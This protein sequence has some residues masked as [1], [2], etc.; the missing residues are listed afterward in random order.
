MCKMGEEYGRGS[1]CVVSN[2]S[3]CCLY[4]VAVFGHR[5]PKFQSPHT[6]RHMQEKDECIT[7]EDGYRQVRWRIPFQKKMPHNYALTH[8]ITTKF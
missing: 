6:S 2:L 7:N 1:L 5:E 8:V 4:R 3:T